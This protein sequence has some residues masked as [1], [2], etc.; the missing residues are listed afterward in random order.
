M[1]SALLAPSLAAAYAPYFRIGAAVSRRNLSDPDAAMLIARHFSSLTAEN[2][3][4][5][6]HLLHREKTLMQGSD[7]MPAL[8]FSPAIPFLDFAREHG[9]AMRFHTLVWHNQTPRWFFARDWSD[10]EDAPLLAPDQMLQR[11]TNYI[12]AVMHYV[13]TNYP[14]LVYA[15]DVVNEAIDPGQGHCDAFRTKSLWY[16]IFGPDYLTEAFRA[17]R[18]CQAE[19]QQLFYNDYDTARPEKKKAVLRLP[20]RLQAEHLVDGMGMQ[21]HLQMHALDIPSCAQAAQAY[22]SLGLH[23][24]I[25]ELDLHCTTAD[26]DALIR[27]ADAYRELFR[28]CLQL[29]R[30]GCPLDAITFWCLT[31]GD[32]WLRAFRKEGSYPLLFAEDKTCKPAFY[33]VLHAMEDTAAQSQYPMA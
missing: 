11:L 23:V 7:T 20:Q 15:W 14:G 6:E 17:A 32:T 33:A 9:I 12:A 25:T 13:N 2:D 3:M 22:A 28:T 4:K 19:G 16:Q 27:Q 8:D 18:A 10:R 5:P 30:E 29:R 31:D 21:G 1:Q 24:Q 26:P